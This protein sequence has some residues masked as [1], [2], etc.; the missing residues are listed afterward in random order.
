MEDQ[1]YFLTATQLRAAAALAMPPAATAV[2]PNAE[3]AGSAR[4]Q[5][6]AALGE[7]LAGGRDAE[8]LCPRR[9]PPPL[10]LDTLPKSCTAAFLRCAACSTNAAWGSVLTVR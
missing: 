8:G 1:T 5:V 4:A 9:S 10:P 3:R 7:T 6:G 2:R